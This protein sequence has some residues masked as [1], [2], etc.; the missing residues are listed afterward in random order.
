MNDKFDELTKGLAQSATRRKALQG[1]GLGLAGA[2]L[3]TLGLSRRAEAKWVCNCASDSLGCKPHQHG[4]L[5]YCACFCSGGQ[6][7]G[8]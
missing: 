5:K 3:A 1:F 8:C 7:S 2:M 6:P 4:C